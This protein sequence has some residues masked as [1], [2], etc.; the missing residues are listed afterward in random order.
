MD[1][2][3]PFTYD[4]KVN[5]NSLDPVIQFISRDYSVNNIKL[6]TSYNEC[7]LPTEFPYNDEYFI[8][9]EN[10]LTHILTGGKLTY[11]CGTNVSKH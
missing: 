9:W 11:D 3:S 8:I 6:A 5:H 1:T 10:W 4:D 7:G 2:R